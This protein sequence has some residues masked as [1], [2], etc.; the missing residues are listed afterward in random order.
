MGPTFYW[1][2]DVM[3]NFFGDFCKKSSD[4]YQLIRLDPGYE[5]YFD[6]KD[7]VKLP[8]D[9][10]EIENTFERYEPGSSRFLNRFLKE[11]EYNYHIVM[12]K[13]VHRPG[14]SP[15]ELIMPETLGRVLQFVTSLS[16]TVHRNLKTERL[17]QILE[18]PVLF[19]GAKPSDI[20]SFYRFMNYADMK[21]GTWHVQGGMYRM[22]GGIK[23]L[24]E[25]LGVRFLTSAT[26]EKI[27]V[28]NRKVSGIRINGQSYPARLVIS[29]A[30]YH[31]TELLLKEEYRN[32]PESY[33]EKRVMAPSAML[34]YIGFNKKLKNVSHH[35]LFFDT[36]FEQHAWKIYN[37]PGWPSRPLFYASFPSITDPELAPEGKEVAI[38]L[39]PVA[40]GLRD[41]AQLKEF[42]FRQILTRMELLT[43]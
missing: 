31:H 24:A 30:D 36:N 21:L 16:Y 43:G 15:L 41:N 37:D 28:H 33:W 29:G 25:E 10:K 38:I 1:M 2:P 13:V 17:R 18:F 32:Y 34:F 5:I 4:F 20:P 8:A 12:D 3:E 42:Y 22:V 23:K 26:V 7:S 27:L 14:K 35:T 40:S 9:F 6:R 19:L 39:I 11:A